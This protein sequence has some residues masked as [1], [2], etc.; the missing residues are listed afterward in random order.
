M[1]NGKRVLERRNIRGETK[2]KI[3]R[4]LCSGCGKRFSLRKGSTKNKRKRFT[5]KFI[6]EAIKDF[7]Q[8]RSSYQ[9]ISQ[10][11]SVSPATLCKWVLAYGSDCLSPVEGAKALGLGKEN[12]WGG[13][14]LLDGKILRRSNPKKEISG[15]V[16]LIATDYLTSDTVSWSVAESEDTESYE[17]LIDSVLKCGYTIRGVVSDDHPAILNL[18]QVS[19]KHIHKIKGTR[20]YPRPGYPHRNLPKIVPRPKLEGIPHQL[21]T[22]H[23]QRE[24]KRILAKAGTPKDKKKIIISM[25][26]KFLFARTER[27][28]RKALRK[29]IIYEY[30]RSQDKNL[31]PG[32]R[33]VINYLYAHQ[34]LLTT[35]FQIK[36]MPRDTNQEENVI[37]YLNTRLK[38]M[39]KLKSM[40]T[41]I[42]TINLI[43]WNFRF[44][45]LSNSKKKGRRGKAP[46]DLAGAKIKGLDWL[47]FSQ[48]S[49]A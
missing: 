48:K 21:C 9:I 7:V 27:K 3:Q 8:G 43:M 10:R 16:L 42:P 29:L 41:A 1:K 47:K 23:S 22:I 49:P 39:K 45:P 17:R 4:Y 6:E 40:K 14:L 20:R 35:H 44:K 33:R 36:G 18:T 24:V 38:T 25:V 5:K 30:Y 13:V 37:G 12:R 31:H 11:K 2:E 26:N 19:S 15:L 32:E 34:I 46:L 28:A